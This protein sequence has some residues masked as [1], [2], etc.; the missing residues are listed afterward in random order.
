MAAFASL[1]RHKASCLMVLVCLIMFGVIY[2]RTHLVEGPNAELRSNSVERI[3]LPQNLGNPQ[4]PHT[5]ATGSASQLP[6]SAA[7]LLSDL[8]PNNDK[9]QR[10]S[11]AIII[12][13]F[14]KRLLSLP[15]AYWNRY[16]NTPMFYKNKSCAKFSSEFDL[17][18]INN[19][20]QNLH[21][22]DGTFQLFGAY[23]DVRQASHT[24]P[25]VRILGMIN[26]YQPT[27]KTYCQFWFESYNE[28]VFSKVLEYKFIWNRKWGNNKEGI[29]HLYLMACQI[30]QQYH[31][32]EPASVS[33]VEKPCDTATNN[34]R[35]VYIKPMR[36]KKSVLLKGL[37]FPY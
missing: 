28:P 19:F 12:E 10:L 26:R 32:M 8:E 34:L 24:G 35:V 6:L 11:E 25:T 2:L 16:K 5:E 30:P 31:K 15:I 23:Y 13:E 29:Y 14:Q 22:S 17:E 33:I 20:W 36:K 3:L 1:I 9:S 21:T 27:I 18:F 7:H 4:T 37:D